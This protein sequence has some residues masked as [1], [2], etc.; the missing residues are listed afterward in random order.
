MEGQFESPAEPAPV[1]LK[2]LSCVCVGLPCH[3]ATDGYEI[4]W[5]HFRGP[6][7]GE[8]ERQL[9]V[10]PGACSCLSF[11]GGQGWAGPYLHCADPEVP[12]WQK[13]WGGHRDNKGCDCLEP[14]ELVVP[15]RDSGCPQRA[16]G[17]AASVPSGLEP[18]GCGQ[19]I[20][21]GQSRCSSR[22]G[23]LNSS[24]TLISTGNCCLPFVQRLVIYIYRL[25]N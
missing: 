11:G 25:R 20:S 15:G 8:G 16:E 14:P 10:N 1:C 24:I 12:P 5:L 2:C 9:W 17:L 18:C 23:T 13:V 19:L 3:V 21:E 22:A 7:H 6:F 4:R